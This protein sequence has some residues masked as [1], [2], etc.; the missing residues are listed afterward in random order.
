[1]KCIIEISYLIILHLNTNQTKWLGFFLLFID[2][3]AMQ[4]VC[5]VVL[6]YFTEYSSEISPAVP[7]DPFMILLWDPLLSR[8]E[9]PGSQSEDRSR[10]LICRLTEC[11]AWKPFLSHGLWENLNRWSGSWLV[12]SLHP[13][14]YPPIPCIWPNPCVEMLSKWQTR[15][16]HF[17]PLTREHSS[18]SLI[19]VYT[20]AAS[21]SVCNG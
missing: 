12:K 10:A 8:E 9:K 17:P 21:A 5:C 14:A 13:F 4:V 19:L 11:V 3:K 2:Y 16:A 15:T 18:A 7:R 6:K 20:S 1:M